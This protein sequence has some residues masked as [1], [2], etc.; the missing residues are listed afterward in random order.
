MPGRPSKRSCMHPDWLVAYLTVCTAAD[1]DSYTGYMNKLPSQQFEASAY[2]VRRSEPD[3]W[4]GRST[5]LR[6]VLPFDRQVHPSDSKSA[7]W[8]CLI[9]E[10]SRHG[11]DMRRLC[12]QAGMSRKGLDVSALCSL[13]GRQR[14][15]GSSTPLC[16]GPHRSRRR[17]RSS[18]ARSSTPARTQAPGAPSGSPL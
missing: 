6:D 13:Q 15:T 7:C 2:P 5:V 18:A 11:N 10:G 14:R 9:G 4:S 8:T 3:A 16:T 12:S 17:C 1:R